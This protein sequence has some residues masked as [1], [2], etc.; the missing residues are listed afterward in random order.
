MSA[1]DLVVE[2]LEHAATIV[3]DLTAP[4]LQRY[5]AACPAS[6]TLMA[7]MDEHMRGRM[8]VDVLTLLMT[9][10]AEV[11][12]GYLHFE[13][14]SHRAYGVEVEQFPDLFDCVRDTVRTLLGSAWNDATARAWQ[15]RIDGHLAAIRTVADA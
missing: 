8:M 1:S 2:S 4:V 7:H 12:Q 5:A 6:A 9:P 3:D 10:P 11:D 15:A 14:A 13:V